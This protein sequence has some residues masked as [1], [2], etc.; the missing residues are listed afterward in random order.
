M[1]EGDDADGDVGAGGGKA[2][3]IGEV[4]DPV[5]FGTVED[6]VGIEAVRVAGVD[7]E[8]VDAEGADSAAS[9]QPFTRPRR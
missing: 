7:A 1:L 5:A 6:L 3:Q 2:A 9:D 4:L 8:G